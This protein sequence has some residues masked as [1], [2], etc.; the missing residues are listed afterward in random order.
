MH[1]FIQGNNQLYNKYNSNFPLGLSIRI[2]F[3]LDL[4]SLILLSTVGSGAGAG[5][6]G[7][8]L[9]QFNGSE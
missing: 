2:N 8:Y 9:D 5:E 3:F 6:A 4:Y 7:M 1:D